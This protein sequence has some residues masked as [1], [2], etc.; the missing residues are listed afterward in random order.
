MRA[1]AQERAEHGRAT[2]KWRVAPEPERA[3]PCPAG[4]L[5]RVGSGDPRDLSSFTAA[6]RSTYKGRAV[7]VLRPTGSAAGSITLSAVAAGLK[8]STVTVKTS[9]GDCNFM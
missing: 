6:V 2:V 5:Y 7:A 9:P 8:S 3:S 4:E 1:R